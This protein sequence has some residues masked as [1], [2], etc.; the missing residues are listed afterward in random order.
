[1]D[2]T[3]TTPKDFFLWAGAMVA[4]YWSIVAF[5]GLIFDYINYAFPNALSYYPSDPYQGGISYEMASLI[6]LFPL[7]VVLMR[8][9]HNDIRKD[10][11]RKSIWVR[12]WALFLTLF[13][14][15]A[16]MAGDV[17]VLLTS[18]LNGS[19]L[20]APFLLKIATVFLVAAAVFMHFMAEY[21]G[22]WD[23]YPSRAHAVGYAAGL[24]ALL[25]IIAGFFI[26]G[27]PGHARQIRMDG[28]K[29]SDLENIQWQIINY[30]QS[31]AVLP[32]QL[33]DLESS[34]SGSVPLDAQ[35]K[36]PYGY[37]VTGTTSFRLCATFNAENYSYTGSNVYPYDTM[38]P[39]GTR[40]IW[41]HAA[42]KVCFDRTIDPDIYPPSKKQ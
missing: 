24:L 30:W 20:T 8:V 27:T 42:G 14:A 11:T 26:V 16:S 28:Q 2:N 4:L 19:D 23:T 29:V 25:T 31:K 39:K 10:S 13:V 35:T 21:W 1:M 15:G 3:K 12:R 41:T 37:E 9:I 22:Y 6:V 38:Y 17:I 40:D 34:F 5:I 18:F 33:H 32:A 7:A 36:T